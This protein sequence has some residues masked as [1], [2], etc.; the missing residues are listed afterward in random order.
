[1]ASHIESNFVH[2]DRLGVDV[3]VVA[4]PGEKCWY[5]RLHHER[6][7]VA[8]MGSDVLEATD[9]LVPGEQVEQRVVRQ[10]D[11]PVSTV[12]P[13]TSRGQGQRNASPT[14]REFQCGVVAG[15]TPEERYGHRFVTAHP[16]TSL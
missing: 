8:P 3:L 4:Q 15:E 16:L 12:D 6:S 5:E 11:Q 14:D 10:A 13:D 1:M 7:V 9:L 2:T